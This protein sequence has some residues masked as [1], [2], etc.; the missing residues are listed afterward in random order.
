MWGKDC[1]QHPDTTVVAV[2]D[3]CTPRT[4]GLFAFRSAWKCHSVD[5]RLNAK[6]YFSI[7]RLFVHRITIE[8]AMANFKVEKVRS[9]FRPDPR[10]VVVAVHSHAPLECVAELDPDIVVAIPCCVP[11][12][13]SADG[14]H[15]AEHRDVAI[16]SQHNIVKTWW[17]EPT[18]AT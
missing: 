17:K 7:D 2:G 3:G 14:Y 5:P 10:M 12:T 6:S 1:L 18:C 13:F 11:Q 8:T 16:L 15:Y 9:S 4:A